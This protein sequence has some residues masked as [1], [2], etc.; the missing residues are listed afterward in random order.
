M[1]DLTIERATLAAAASVIGLL[2][3]AATWQQRHGIDMWEPG[4]FEEDV[5]QTIENGDLYV[6]HRDD[7]IVGCFMLDDGSPRMTQWLLD[8][9]REPSKGVV[10]RLVVAR[11][12]A[13]RGLGLQLLRHAE[14][15]ARAEGVSFLRL[16]CPSNDERLRR[17]YV[18]AGFTYCGDNDLPGPHAEPWVSSVYERPIA[19]DGP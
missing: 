9:G 19:A 12:A 16:E 17:Y 3:A 5:R 15:L 13:G 14:R 4:T 6:A 1:S 7:A 18:E 10:G 11:N 2:D 8:Q